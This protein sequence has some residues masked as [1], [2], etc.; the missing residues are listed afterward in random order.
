MLSIPL[1]KINATN[2]QLYKESVMKSSKDKQIQDNY[3]VSWLF[4]FE[5]DVK[6]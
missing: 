1:N 6:S 5:F 3:I 2:I 4:K